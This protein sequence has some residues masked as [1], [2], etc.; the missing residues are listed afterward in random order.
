M[1]QDCTFAI[2][3]VRQEGIGSS[4]QPFC[5]SLADYKELVTRNLRPLAHNKIPEVIYCQ[6]FV[7][8]LTSALQTQVE[9][10]YRAHLGV[11][12]MTRNA[13][14]TLLKEAIAVAQATNLEI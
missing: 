14:M 10:K 5:K 9:S 3:N 11:Q 8:C 1:T 4:G 12:I 7:Q 2:W 6:L 13:Q